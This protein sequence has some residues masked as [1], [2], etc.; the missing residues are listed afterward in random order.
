MASVAVVGPGSVGV[1]FAGHLAAAG[2]DVTAC[3][4]RPFERYVIESPESPLDH[5]A[6]VL[7][8]AAEVSAPVE[9]VLLAVKAH[10][11]AGAQDWLAA[12]CDSTTRVLVVQNGIEHDRANEYTNGA[13]TIPTVVYC[14]AELLEPGHIRHSSSGFLM[15][16]DQPH[17]SDML[18]LFEGSEAEVRPTSNFVTHKWRKLSLNVMANGLTALTGRTMAVLAEAPIRSMAISLLRECWTVAQ[19]DGADL[20]PEE[21]TA[22]VD[23][24]IAS[25][26][27][28]GTSMLYDTRAG[29]PTEHDAI[30][31]SALRRAEALDIDVPTIRFVHGILDARSRA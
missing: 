21:A 23:G 22:L 28:T 14:G 15:V 25:G 31:G 8:D 12:L 29:R 10:Q 5:P 4:R 9:W 27:D 24:I 3:A 11:T 7:T 19:A 26:R 1:F 17:G 16:P 13:D 30:H 20:D 18:A 6:N 2:H